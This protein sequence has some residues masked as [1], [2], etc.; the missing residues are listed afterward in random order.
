MSTEERKLRQRDEREH[1][2]L[3]VGRKMLIERGY[4]GL[5]MDRIAQ[6]I[7][8]SK[9]IVYQHFSSKEDMLCA[10]TIEMLGDMLGLFRRAVEFR[11]RTRERIAAVATAAQLQFR[12]NP[13]HLQ[14]QQILWIASIAHKASNERR[15]EL[16]RLD[17]QAIGL[18][19]Q[20]IDAAVA[21]GDLT[22]PKGIEPQQLVYGMW[23]M[24]IGAEVLGYDPSHEIVF[25][26]LNFGRA[27]RRNLQTFLDGLG[28]QP[29]SS[30]WDYEK[31]VRRVLQTVFHDEW[32]DLKRK[33]LELM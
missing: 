15:L 1:L 9:G 20:L 29:L 16:D 3:R 5:N 6:E 14:A 24:M 23:S 31:T 19:E 26:K 28:W 27:V 33:G 2:I 25:G 7:E 4:L 13:D 11:G 30:D 8:Y 12:L 22:V 10:M 17:A 21:D 18:F 32:S